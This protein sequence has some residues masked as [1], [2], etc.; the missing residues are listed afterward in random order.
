MIAKTILAKPEAVGQCIF[1][2][3]V[4]SLTLNQVR[5]LRLRYLECGKLSVAGAT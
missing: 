2:R 3:H 4:P 5:S 1:H